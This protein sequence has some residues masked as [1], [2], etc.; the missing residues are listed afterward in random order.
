MITKSSQGRARRR[1]AELGPGPYIYCPGC[2]KGE[3]QLHGVV[4]NEKFLALPNAYPPA[5]AAAAA[6]A[7]EATDRIMTRRSRPR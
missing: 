4:A 2:W 1:S 7:D 3:T 6:L 5:L